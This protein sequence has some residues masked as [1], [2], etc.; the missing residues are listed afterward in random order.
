MEDVLDLYT[1]PYDP[2][3]PQVCFDE[4][5]KQL[6]GETRTPLPAKSGQPERYDYEYVRN[7]V[8]NLFMF[9]APLHNWRHVKV[10]EHRT[11]EDWAH[12]MRDLVDIHFPD[13][14]RIRLVEDNLNTHDPAALYEVFEPAEAKRILD[15]LEFHYT[16]KHGSWLNMA[17]IELSVLS[18]Q[19]LDQRIPD[20]PCL[21]HEVAAWETDRNA[22]KATVNWRFTTADARIK[23]KRLYPSIEL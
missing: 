7:G 6:I 4:T 1:L 18:G 13:A 9:C 22:A 8:A 16:P 15:R 3:Y 14:V 12:C 17:E 19:C 10:T 11:K 5:S 21:E 23:L 2:R 20:Q